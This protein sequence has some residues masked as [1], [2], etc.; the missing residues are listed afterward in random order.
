MCRVR[1]LRPRPGGYSPP[2]AAPP[3][4]RGSSRPHRCTR[5]AAA[6]HRSANAAGAAAAAAA[7]PAR[8]SMKSRSLGVWRKCARRC[9]RRC[10]RTTFTPCVHTA[11][12]RCT[13]AAC[14]ARVRAARRARPAPHDRKHDIVTFTDANLARF[15]VSWARNLHSL[16]LPSLVGI[17]V[18][19]GAAAERDLHRAN[20]G[21]FCADSYLTRLNSAAGRWADLVPLLNFGVDVLCSD[22]DVGW[23]Q[24]PLPYLRA[25]VDAHPRAEL[26]LASDRASARGGRRVRSPAAVRRTSILKTPTRT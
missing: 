15:A 11:R 13:S 26:F 3:L 18:R 2:P 22:A 5:G 7:R 17:A 8:R 4:R 23:L 6:R 12:P 1:P 25:A 14:A 9:T 16:G 10:R 20:S 19:L 21:L 24:S